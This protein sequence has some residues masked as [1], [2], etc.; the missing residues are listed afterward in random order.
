MGGTGN[1]VSRLLGM[2]SW[3]T[4]SFD[5]MI[6]N[7]KR[8]EIYTYISMKISQ[9]CSQYKPKYHVRLN[10]Y[11]QRRSDNAHL[12]REPLAI[13][14]GQFAQETGQYSKIWDR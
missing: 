5:S 10:L 1:E 2:L 3:I 9:I 7:E 6:L 14:L 12:E 4:K 11:G 13:G 8:G